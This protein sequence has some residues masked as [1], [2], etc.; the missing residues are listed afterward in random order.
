MSARRRRIAGF[1][2]LALFVGAIV[3]ELL[4]RQ[5]WLMGALIGAAGV[6]LGAYISSIV[7]ERS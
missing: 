3:A 4:F 5:S 1:L 7:Q 2:G 6:C